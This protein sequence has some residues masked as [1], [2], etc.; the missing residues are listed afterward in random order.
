[1][2]IRYKLKREDIWR[3]YW[4][5]WRHSWKLKAAQVAI[6]ASVFYM[7]VTQL[8]GRGPVQVRHV[9]LS[10]LITLA[11]LVFLPVYPLIRFKPQERSLTIGPEGI[12]T[13]IGTLSGD[14]PWRKVDS[15]A[16]ENDRIYI[17]GK[18]QNAFA[19]PDHAFSTRE[20]RAEFL[21]LAQGWFEKAQT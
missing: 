14:V 3:T 10:V 17:V 5:Q 15:V 2:T 6:A 1:M 19:V 7:A 9:S 11:A 4:R 16:A 12:T 18:N 20:E 13:T 21:Q 8:A